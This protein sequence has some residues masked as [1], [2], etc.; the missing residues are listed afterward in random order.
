MD[1]QREELA[2]LGMITLG[3]SRAKEQYSDTQRLLFLMNYVEGFG[4]LAQDR[5]EYALQVADDNGRS[6]PTVSD[7]LEGFRRM[8]DDAMEKNT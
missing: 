1:D 2:K 3:R 6:E 5:H 8:C 4:T 7:Y